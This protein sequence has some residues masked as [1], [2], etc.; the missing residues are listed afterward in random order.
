M[1]HGMSAL[2][3]G[4]SGSGDTGAMI[5]IVAQIQGTV[6]WI[7]MVSK[8]AI[9]FM[10]GYIVNIVVVEHF[11]CDFASRHAIVHGY[12]RVLFEFRFDTFACYKTENGQSAKHDPNNHLL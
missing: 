12:F 4:D 9:D 1:L 2:V 3:S 6:H 11:L 8:S 7:V 10:N 5:D